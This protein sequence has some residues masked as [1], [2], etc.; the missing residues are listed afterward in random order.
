MGSLDMDFSKRRR[1]SRSYRNNNSEFRSQSAEVR[2]DK[3]NLPSDMDLSKRRRGSRSSENNDSTEIRFQMHGQK[4]TATYKQMLESI[5]VRIQSTCDSPTNT[6][7]SIR[8]EQKYAP[9]KPKWTRVRIL[10]DDTDDI[11]DEKRSLQHEEDI[12]YMWNHRKYIHEKKRLKEN[13]SKTYAII[14]GLPC[15]RAMRNAIE[16]DPLRLLALMLTLMHTRNSLKSVSLETLMGARSSTRPPGRIG[17]RKLWK[18]F[19]EDP[20]ST[21][22]K[23]ATVEAD[24]IKNKSAGVRIDKLK[25]AGVRI[26]K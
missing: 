21:I 20:F 26:E 15:T 5:L 9:T 3:Y 17:L 16:E 6:T 4:E 14:F 25:S 11:V 8:E 7:K 18:I 23:K 22:T 24:E 13:W 10:K 2:I 19:F 1:G 12:K